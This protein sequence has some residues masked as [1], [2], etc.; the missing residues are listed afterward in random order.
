[1]STTLETDICILGGGIAGLWLNARL[2]QL[3][4]S[5]LLIE[6]GALGG[7]QSSKSQGIIHGGTKYALH[8]K[9]SLAAEAIGDMPERWR[10]C[11]DGT[12]ELDLTGVR[13]LSEHHYLWSP[14]SLLSNMA[15]FFASK[16]LRGRVDTVKGSERPDVFDNP[17]FKGKVY[18]LAELV[19]DVPDAIRRLAELSGNSLVVDP[20]PH[21]ESRPDGS[22]EGIAIHDYLIKAQRYVLTAGEGNEGLLNSWGV[23]QPAMQRRPLQMVLVKGANLPMEHVQ[24]SVTGWPAA[25]CGGGA[26][27]DLLHGDGLILSGPDRLDIHSSRN[28]PGAAGGADSAHLAGSQGEAPGVKGLP[29]R[30]A[31]G[32]GPVPGQLH[33]FGL[34]PRQTQGG[35]QPG[36]ARRA[37]DD[38]VAVPG[39]LLRRHEVQTEP[40][41]QLGASRVGVHHL[42]D[43]WHFYLA[44]R[45][46][47]IAVQFR[48]NYNGIW[49]AFNHHLRHS[50]FCASQERVGR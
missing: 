33:H 27:D 6:R 23:D 47:D 40:A 19:L 4:Y 42:R 11:L 29:Q 32:I 30:H 34:L 44:L 7:G 35:G 13:L 21:V 14:G 38:D 26:G 20:S 2:Q 17:A 36:L 3:G 46:I 37:V 28:V 48:G 15:G 31:R 10:A 9:L 1:M 18:R 5:T 16:A 8:G 39:R 22:I 25:G 43:G 24:A 41:S 50:G 49:P 45:L 12:G